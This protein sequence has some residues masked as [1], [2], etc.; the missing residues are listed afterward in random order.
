[1]TSLAER[2]IASLRHLHDDLATLVPTLSSEQLSAPS[3]ASEWTVAQVLS[4]LGSG[5]EIATATYRAELDGVESPGQDFNQNVWDRWNAMS[6]QEQAD[7]F[8]ETDAALVASLESLT[9]E[10]RENTMIKLGFLPEPLPLAAVAGMRLNEV[11]QHA[12]DVRVA[13]D[14]EATLDATAARIVLEHYTGGLGFLLA[15]T[16]KTDQLTEAAEVAIDGTDHALAIADRV[17][18]VPATGAPTATLTGGPDAAVRLLG[19]RLTPRY[20]PEGVTVAGNVTLD[21]LRRVFP[22]Y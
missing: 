17:A 18:L 12:W 9:P 21:D 2:T 5:A 22:G 13:Q 10:Q 1:M 19:G 6:P 4:H 20:T 11:T 8:V 14:P 15:F 16:G 7:G 3:G